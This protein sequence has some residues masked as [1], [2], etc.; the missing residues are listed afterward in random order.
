MNGRS[1]CCAARRRLA[2]EE[3]G[4]GV[5]SD[6]SDPSVAAPTQA[7]H[8]IDTTT[9]HPA[10]RYNYWLGGKDHFAADRESGDAVA[11]AFPTA[12]VSA[13]ENRAFMRR[14]VTFLTREVGIRQFLDIGTG[15]PAPNNTHEV[16]QAIAPETHVAYV[17]N[18]PIVLSH[19]RALLSSTP[20]GAT[21]YIE[22]D[23]RDY[24]KILLHPD[25]SR[26]IDLSRPVALMMVAI[27]H[28]LRD[29]E[30]PYAIVSSL[31]EA[32]PTG[33]FLV[34]SHGTA[35]HAPAQLRAKV[36]DGIKHGVIYPRTRDEV[37]RF[38]DGLDLVEPGV[39]SVADW[40]PD[41][42]SQPRLTPAETATYGAVGRVR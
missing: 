21:S 23:L 2:G 32:L 34:V 8:R 27:L 40:R 11:A 13:L 5:S 22:A 35:D 9:A 29:E 10:R 24:Q 38:F 16:A 19:A 15:I 6:E 31:I 30:N 20:D 25:V 36:I 7:Q 33:S 12:R 42:E 17:D 1:V 3:M 37:E 26:I 14:A 4:T 28:F 41:D 18:D 39:V